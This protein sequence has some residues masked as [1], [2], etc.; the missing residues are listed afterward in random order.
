MSAFV[1]P[2]AEVTSSIRAKA[3]QLTAAATSKMAK[4]NAI[5][6]FVQQTR[7]V[8]ISLNLTRGGVPVLVKE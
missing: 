6:A 1:D 5:A 2:P 3:A 8:A 4:I 7:Y